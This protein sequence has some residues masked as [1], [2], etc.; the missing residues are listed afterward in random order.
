MGNSKVSKDRLS[1][2]K[3]RRFELRLSEQELLQFLELE[4]SLCISRADIV[5]IRVLKNSANLLVNA[6]ALMKQLDTIGAELGRSGNNINQLARHANILHKQGLLNQSVTTEFNDLLGK[7]IAVQ[8]E[9]EKVIRQII[10]QM[11][12]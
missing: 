3:I 1:A 5:R 7:Y 4:K 6:K 11:K 2:P 9:L 10:R 8:Q 12:G